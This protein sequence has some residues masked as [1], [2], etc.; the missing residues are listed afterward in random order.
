MSGAVSDSTTS[1]GTGS[2]SSLDGAF[3]TLDDRIELITRNLDEVMGADAAVQKMRDIIAD[4]PLKI[5][6]GTATTGMHTPYTH[7]DNTMHTSTPA[8]AAYVDLCNCD[9]IWCRMSVVVFM[10]TV[11]YVIC[12]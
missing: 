8:F 4:R 12:V 6:W 10:L 1:T 3:L 11:L 2:A 9:N 5:Y 7:I